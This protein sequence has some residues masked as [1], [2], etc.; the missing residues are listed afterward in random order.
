M[1]IINPPKIVTLCGST[2]FKKEFEEATRLLSIEGKIVLSVACFTHTDKIQTTE[3]Q[4]ILFD[5]L[6]KQKI[7]MSDEIFVIDIGD[8]IGDSTQEEIE[9]ARNLGKTIKYYSNEIKKGKR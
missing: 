8:Y 6:H 1:N 3:E 2:R 7:D 4:K 5:K 9:Y